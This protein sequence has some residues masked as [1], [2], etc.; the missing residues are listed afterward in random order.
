M[1]S[2]KTRFF[3]ISLA[4]LSLVAFALR[5]WMCAEVF[6]TDPSSFAPP[7]ATDMATYRALASDVLRGIFPE[8][9][10]YQP[11]YYSVFLP[12]AM[13]LGGPLWGMGTLQ[14]LCAAGVAVLSALIAARLHSRIA[15]LIAA[16]LCAFSQML[17]FYV[18]YAL[19][20][21][22]QCLW[23]TLLVWLV[24]RAMDRRTL[25]SWAC[26]G[27]VFSFAILSRGN[28]W[29]LLPSILVALLLSGADLPKRRRLLFCAVFLAAALLPQIPFA[30]RN[31]CADG[32]LSGP[33]AAGPAVL[34]IGNNPEGAP[35]GLPVPYPET[36]E[37]W[38]RHADEISIPRRILTWAREEPLAF[39]LQQA[40]KT[41]LFWDA[42]EIPNNIDLQWNARESKAFALF[43]FVP[44]SALLLFSLSACFLAL[45]R[46]RGKPRFLFLIL[47]LASYALATSAF[48]LLARFRVPILGVLAALSGIFLASLLSAVGKRRGRLLLRG[49]APATLFAAFLVFAAYP[50]WRAGYEAPAMRL[51]RPDGVRLLEAD[52]AILLD[53]APNY[54]DGWSLLPLNGRIE[55]VKRFSAN[56]LDSDRNEWKAATLDLA[57]LPET[58]RPFVIECNGM[59]MVRTPD[60]PG[61]LSDF[62]IGPIP[63]PDDLSFRISFPGLPKDALF[64]PVDFHR[65]YGRTKVDAEEAPFEAVV[66][67]TLTP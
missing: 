25:L 11:F 34:A 66:R 1:K 60:A 27:L 32:S 39:L 65:S 38:M 49:F 55:V 30:W 18:P 23:I 4:L 67:L 44:T 33:S 62:R 5:L 56:G 24:L 10:V 12:L 53:H 43:G 46:L 36:Y 20:E 14:A 13:A 52:R 29:L 58:T 40:Q 50:L 41:L 17:F 7:P 54:L 28:A 64:L 61:F 42:R 6:Q 47:F 9:F 19:I 3:F 59:R 31:T 26:A 37:S 16:A 45:P 22:Q 57:L 8:R 15:G 35:G 21:I 2:R 51:A 63:V 48:Y